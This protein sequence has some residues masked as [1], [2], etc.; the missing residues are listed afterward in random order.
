MSKFAR[1]FARRQWHT[2]PV[3]FLFKQVG[4]MEPAICIIIQG[5][6]LRRSLQVVLLAMATTGRINAYATCTEAVLAEVTPP[7]PALILFDCG[8]DPVKPPPNLPLLRSRWPQARMVAIVEDD[9]AAALAGEAG[10]DLVVVQGV[11]AAQ[12]ANAILTL[13]RS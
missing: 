5:E 8:V 6:R 11:P 12:L 9:A 2:C 3:E 13:A 10:V 1:V 4:R 7:E